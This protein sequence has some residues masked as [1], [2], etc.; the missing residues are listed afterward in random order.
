MC[1]DTSGVGSDYESLIDVVDLFIVDVKSLDK[2]EYK[3]IAGLEIDE[4]YK[5]MDKI[6]SK[7]KKLWLRQVIVPN[8]NDKEETIIKLAEYANSLKNVE[9][10][11]LLAYH[12]MAEEKYER[13]NMK[14]RL[15]GTDNLSFEKIEQ[16]RTVLNDHLNLK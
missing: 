1:I 12:A 3:Y 5:F 9:K 11:E 4:F 7:S 6:Q 10:V 15:A 2:E 13:L 8:I 16:L 14:Y